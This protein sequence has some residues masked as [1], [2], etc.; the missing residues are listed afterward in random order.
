[1]VR[2]SPAY[3]FIGQD[4]LSK[5]V[6]LASLKQEFL[7]RDIQD[8]NY[9]I[10]H[11]KDTPLKTLQEKLLFLPAKS[12]KRMVVFRDIGNARQEV[13]EFILTY[14]QRPFPQI[15]LVLDAEKRGQK[16]DFINTLAKSCRV[17]SFNETIPVDTF[18]LNRQ[19]ERKNISGA[20]LLL[21]E[22]LENGEKP[23][24]ILGG[25]RYALE[26]NT[27]HPYRLRKGLRIL[28]GCD[29]EIKTGKLKPEFALERLVV[30]LSS[31]A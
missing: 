8:F 3:L 12:N 16:D 2:E 14:V 29:L 1:M 30:R 19:I 15:L 9:D 10:L 31:L 11:A 25:L 20:L 24:R 18:A 23:E 5:D 26:K 6:K 27:L 4:S 13:R 21:H 7:P 22:L 17:V 28:L